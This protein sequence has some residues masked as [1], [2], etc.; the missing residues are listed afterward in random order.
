MGLIVKNSKGYSFYEPFTH[1]VRDSM[2]KTNKIKADSKLAKVFPYQKI[3]IDN[4]EKFTLDGE[5]MMWE[6]S[7][8]KSPLYLFPDS[9]ELVTAILKGNFEGK[10]TNIAPKYDQF[11]IAIPQ[12]S[13]FNGVHIPGIYVSIL[14]HDEAKRQIKAFVNEIQIDKMILMPR[15]DDRVF[16]ISYR[17][18]RDGR[19][20]AVSKPLSELM[21]YMET[22]TNETQN[23][24]IRFVLGF[25]IYIS[26]APDSVED[27]SHIILPKRFQATFDSDAAAKPTSIGVHFAGDRKGTRFHLR[28][29]MN[30]MY[31][32]G[33]W[34][35]YERGTRWVFVK[36]SGKKVTYH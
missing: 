28:C 6:H 31:Y 17:T 18:C 5:L 29:L 12:K 33:E 32:Q 23:A 34:E 7:W 9:P 26:A 19:T 36:G 27:A 3:Y 25:L 8:L 16:H 10:I 21:S 11:S 1:M 13:K 35:A 15:K 14:S 24:V 20:V 30:E 22:N 2:L 4:E